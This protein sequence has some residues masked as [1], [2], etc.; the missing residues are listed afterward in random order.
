MTS[1]PFRLLL[2]DDNA[3]DRQLVLRLLK[4]EVPELEVIEPLNQK[5]LDYVLKQGNFNF[6][7]TDYQLHW[8]TG[9]DILH[10]V[11]SQYP[12]C[13]IVM[14]TGTGNEEI[15]VEAMKAGLD[16]YVIK[17]PKHFAQ[18]AASIRSLWELDKQRRARKEIENRYRRLFDGV[19]IGLYRL[20]STAEVIDANPMFIQMLGYQDLDEILHQNI[21]SIHVDSEHQQTWLRLLTIE[22]TVKNFETELHRRDG[23]PIWVRHT[24][25]PIQDQQGEVFYYEGSL[26][27]ISEQKLA[28]QERSQLLQQAQTAQQQAEEASRLKDEFLATLSHELRTPLNAMLGWLQLLRQGRLSAEQQTQALETIERNAKAQNQLIGDILDVSR[29]I[30]GKVKLDMISLNPCQAIESAID[31]IRPTANS[32]NIQLQLDCDSPVGLISADPNRLQ[33]VIWNLLVNA[34]KFTPA[35][36]KITVEV[37]RL[38]DQI[39]ISVIDTGQGIAAEDLPY[40]FERFRQVEQG[41]KRPQGGLG[42]GLSIVRYLIEMH[43]GRV[44]VSSPGLG[45]GTTFMIYLPRPMPETSSSQQAVNQTNQSLLADLETVRI[46]LVEDEQDSRE[47]INFILTDCGANVIAVGSV[48]E[49]IAQLDTQPPFNLLI[50]DIAMPEVDGYDL[51]QQ[52]RTRYSASDLPAIA[53]TA[54]AREVDRTK[55][56]ASGFQQHL[57]KPIEATALITTIS[58][59][60]QSC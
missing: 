44:A 2:I 3:N 20:S 22:G 50:S 41:S 32:K 26:E 17:S 56:I 12:L 24:I 53:L 21:I 39:Q 30:R 60:I 45:H 1:S 51:I 9:L 14:F 58:E 37:K 31:S 5:D 59:F 11:K 40:V 43:G 52:V 19:P 54:Y 8:T 49:A 13:P 18:L 55:A 35:S 4:R 46:L 47:F 16:D 48:A 25:K 29:I 6:I 7:I 10:Q 57:A 42:L 27:D 38:D 36:G 33:Q 34:I 28:E 15:A 23:M